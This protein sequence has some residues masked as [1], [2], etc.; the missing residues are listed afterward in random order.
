[1]DESHPG[2]W[3][4]LYWVDPTVMNDVGRGG[5]AGV[6]GRVVQR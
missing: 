1:M 4:F 3:D 2:E 6:A 5:Y